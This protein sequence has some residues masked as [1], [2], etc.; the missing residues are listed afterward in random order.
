[1]TVTTKGHKMNI[2]A[3]H[4]PEQKKLAEVMKEDVELYDIIDH[5]MPEVYGK[6]VIDILKVLIILTAMNAIPAV[7]IAIIWF[8]VLWSLGIF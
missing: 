8:F 5:D 4:K 1:M 7:T 2:Y 6:T 3:Q